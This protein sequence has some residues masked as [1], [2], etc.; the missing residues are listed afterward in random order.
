MVLQPITNKI[1]R[2][3]LLC[4]SIPI[5]FQELILI[6]RICY[7]VAACKE[8]TEKFH[9]FPGKDDIVIA[10][11]GGYDILK[12]K[13]LIPDVVIG[14]F[15]SIEAE[16]PCKNIIRH[17]VEKDDT[18]T[19]LALKLALEKGYNNFVIFGGVGGRIDHTLANIQA[20]LWVV[21]RGGRAFLIGNDVV[22]TV[23][24]NEKFS[25][26]A[27]HKGK[28]SVFAQEGTAKGV[29]IS[30]LKYSAENLFLTPE[31]PL[32]VSN[33]FVGER[34]EISVE[35]GSLLIVWEQKNKD[36]IEQIN[37]FTI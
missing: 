17:P 2:K 14:D 9:I 29:K 27:S 25:F 33:E 28:A 15:D 23:I 30:G 11:D 31:F 21:K 19:F 16:M 4:Y 3:I 7:I 20:L 34:A 13:N 32:G 1:D 6:K 35:D 37:N 22:M 12:E 8:N 24:S 36:F 18:D 26:A 10:A 5:N